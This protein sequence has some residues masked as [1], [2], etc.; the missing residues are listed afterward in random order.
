MVDIETLGTTED[1]VILQIG[2]VVFDKYDENTNPIK[3]EFLTDMT[4]SDQIRIYKRTVDSDTLI[5]W[6]DEVGSKARE[7]V[8]KRYTS[9]DLLICSTYNALE[10]F[11]NF[12]CSHIDEEDHNFVWSNSP[13]FDL[14]I[15]KHAMRQC[16]IKPTWNHW[17]ERDVRTMHHINRTLNLGINKK[18]DGVAHNA[19]DD[20][21]A[22]AIY[23]M[24]IQDAL[25]EIKRSWVRHEAKPYTFNNNAYKTSSIDPNDL[26]ISI[27]E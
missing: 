11:N 26:S 12:V 10:D 3:A 21:K 5:W 1:S 6:I 18:I 4:I 13:S 8:L 17:E 22:Q 27:Q 15:I 7:S 14:A 16:D 25:D 24:K 2:A 9:N 23:V 20:A 19:L